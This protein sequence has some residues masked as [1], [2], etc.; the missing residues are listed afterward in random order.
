MGRSLFRS[1]PALAAVLAVALVGATSFAVAGQGHDPHGGWWGHG[2]GHGHKASHG[3][4]VSGLDERWLKVH[5]QTN[6][7]EIAG[8]KLAQAR[9]TTDA[10][11]G[12]GAELVA[13]HTAAQAQTEAVAAKVGVVLPTEPAPL[14]QWASRAV[15]QFQGAKFDR[16]FADLNVEGHKQ[17]IVEASTEAAKGCNPYVRG[18]AASSLPVLERHLAHAQAILAALPG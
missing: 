16:W 4:R 8:G 11:R 3:K 15:A 13:D 12:L 7:F 9:A 2:H 1:L 17:A 6:L 18:L 10:V 14:Q 5:A